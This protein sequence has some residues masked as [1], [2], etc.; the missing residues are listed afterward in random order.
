MDRGLVLEVMTSQAWKMKGAG[1]EPPLHTL[2][3]YTHLHTPGHT[4]T[5]YRSTHTYSMQVMLI[6]H[7]FTLSRAHR[8]VRTHTHTSGLGPEVCTR[9]QRR[10]AEWAPRLPQPPGHPEFSHRATGRGL[11]GTWS[12]ANGQL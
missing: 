11:P 9:G 2:H 10:L 6:S 7:A 4:H 3:T 8:H 12:G 1:Q 5:L